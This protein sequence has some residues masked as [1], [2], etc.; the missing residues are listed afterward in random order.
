MTAEVDQ[1]VGALDALLDHQ[2]ELR[3]ARREHSRKVSVSQTIDAMLAGEVAFAAGKIVADPIAEA[4]SMAAYKLGERLNE[5][6]GMAAMSDALV[7]VC[8]AAP[9]QAYWREGYLDRRW[10]GIGEWQA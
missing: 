4:I 1:I 3:E 10:S 5:I 9:D 7:A 8:E 2:A 6:G